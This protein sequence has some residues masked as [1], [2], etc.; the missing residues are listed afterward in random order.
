MLW[1]RRIRDL[2]ERAPVRLR[3]LGARRAVDTAVRTET[4]P[5]W[6]SGLRAMMTL[7]VRSYRRDAIRR[8]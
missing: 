3:R 8:Q 5:P 6:A 1:V 4:D 7:E 2:P